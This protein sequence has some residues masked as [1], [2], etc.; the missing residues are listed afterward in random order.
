MTRRTRL[1]SQKI[2][3]AGYYSGDTERKFL[4]ESLELRVALLVLRGVSE[5]SSIHKWLT[6]L[7]YFGLVSDFQQN[8]YFQKNHEGETAEIDELLG[9][10]DSFVE[11]STSADP[12]SDFHGILD[13]FKT[14]WE[15]ISRRIAGAYFLEVKT[16]GD[17]EAVEIAPTN[18]TAG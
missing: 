12:V 13:R 6:D 14:E 9:E 5:K 15:R 8:G 7:D 10:L 1:H 2:A 18:A 11:D 17:S 4:E 3:R 16:T